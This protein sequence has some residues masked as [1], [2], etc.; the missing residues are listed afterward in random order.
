[1]I[2]RKQRPDGRHHQ[3]VIVNLQAPDSPTF[4]ALRSQMVE[5][6]LP[7]AEKRRQS[8]RESSILIGA[9]VVGA[10]V[11]GSILAMTWGLG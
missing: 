11:V 3:R 5:A 4:R 1:M 6:A 10:V 9:L 7:D 2:E 8:D